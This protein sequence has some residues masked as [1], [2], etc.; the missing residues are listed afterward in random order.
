[1]ILPCPS[2]YEGHRHQ[3]NAYCGDGLHCGLFH[4]KHLRPVVECWWALEHRAMFTVRCED[5][6]EVDCQV[7]PLWRH[8]LV[9]WWWEGDRPYRLSGLPLSVLPVVTSDPTMPGH[10]QTVG[11]PS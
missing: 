3:C 7:A 1:V 9:W 5:A 2:G 6:V 10:W 4:G 8:W 11:L